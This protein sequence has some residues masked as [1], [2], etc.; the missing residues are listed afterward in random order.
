M[1]KT[2]RVATRESNLAI[3]QSKWVVN[4]IK[5]KFP[6]L[7]FELIEIKTTGD[8]ILNKRLDKIGGK[9]LFI[10]ELEQALIN[11]LVD[12]AVHSMKDM[13]AE[14][15]EELVIAAISEREDSR[16]VLVTS[17]GRTLEDLGSGAVL[18]TSS[19]RREIQIL[20]KRPDLVIKTLRGN[21]LTRINKLVNCEYDAI[22]L[23]LAGLRRLGLEERNAQYFEVDDII[24]AVGQGAIGIE[25]R[26]DYDI[27]YLLESIHCDES[28][29]RVNAERAFMIRLNGGCSTPIAAHAVIEESKIKI[30]G[31][32][33][34]EDKLKVI[35]ACVEGNRR[36]AVLLGEKL[37]DMVSG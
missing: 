24:P 25:T 29:L 18:G 28:A 11:N 23:A 26:K 27:A 22:M 36:E 33:A 16:D 13:P 31:M 14:L 8:A 12:I 4:K 2:I 32:L 9:G 19:V 5:K 6:F 17:D 10:K 35:R 3:A 34:S 37:A 20:Q 7:K 15:P 30:Y 1:K 21:V